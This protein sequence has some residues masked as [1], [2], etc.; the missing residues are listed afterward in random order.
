MK[1]LSIRRRVVSTASVRSAQNL[2]EAS[3]AISS[4]TG[5]AKASIASVD[6]PE[7][8]QQVGG[9]NFEV[10]EQQV[11][12]DGIERRTK[13]VQ[14]EV[15]NVQSSSNSQKVSL[16]EQTKLL[17][18]NNKCKSID[19]KIL[20][21][22]HQLD[23][24][25]QTKEES[26][27]AKSHD[28]IK[29]A[30]RIKEDKSKQS[31]LKANE[32]NITSEQQQQEQSA[33]INSSCKFVPTGNEEQQQQQATGV[34]KKGNSFLDALIEGRKSWF[35][36]RTIIVDIRNTKTNNNETNSQRRDKSDLIKNKVSCDEKCKIIK[37]FDRDE[38]QLDSLNQ[39]NST[40]NNYLNNEQFPN[41]SKSEKSNNPTKLASKS[42][43]QINTKT[44]S[45]NNNNKTNNNSGYI[46]NKLINNDSS[47]IGEQGSGKLIQVE[48][49][50]G[51]DKKVRK[52]NISSIKEQ[53]RQII[54]NTPDYKQLRQQQQD[55]ETTN[56]TKGK[57][58]EERQLK[59]QQQQVG[60]NK[61]TNNPGSTQ[62]PKGKTPPT[63]GGTPYKVSRLPYYSYHGRARNVDLITAADREDRLNR[64]R[65]SSN[66]KKQSISGGYIDASQSDSSNSFDSSSGGEPEKSSSSSQIN[67]G[68]SKSAAS[69]SAE[70]AANSG[71]KVVPTLSRTSGYRDSRQI[72]EESA[73]DDEYSKRS[74]ERQNINYSNESIE[75]TNL[76]STNKRRFF[77]NGFS[78]ISNLFPDQQM[79]NYHSSKAVADQQRERNRQLRFNSEERLASRTRQ[80]Q[81]WNSL[82]NLN[83][84]SRGKTSGSSRFAPSLLSRRNSITNYQHTNNSRYIRPNRS[85][86]SLDTSPYSNTSDNQ[87]QQQQQQQQR[88]TMRRQNSNSGN[89]SGAKQRGA[90][91]QGRSMSASSAY[92]SRHHR[93]PSASSLHY[94]SAGTSPY[95]PPPIDPDCP[96]HGYSPVNQVHSKSSQHLASANSDADLLYEPYNVG[97]YDRG[98]PAAAAVP[99]VAAGGSLYSPISPPLIDRSQTTGLVGAGGG[100]YPVQG[101]GGRLLAA[102]NG[103]PNA[104]YNNTSRFS[105]YHSPMNGLDNVR[106][107]LAPPNEQLRRILGYQPHARPI[108]LHPQWAY[109]RPFIHL[110][111]TRTPSP[112]SPGLEGDDDDLIGGIGS[113]GADI[114]PRFEQY[115]QL[116]DTQAIRAVDFHP[117]GEVYAVG[118]NSRALRICAYPADY[119]LRHFSHDHVT[120]APRILFKFLQV[121]RG[122][123]YCVSFNSTGQ[124]L[125]TGSNDQTV[126]IVKYN[127]ITHS[128]DGDEYRLT[129][130][131]GTVRDLCFIDDSP[132]NGHSSI[133]LSAGGG[134]NKIY[135]TDCDT[136]TPFQSMAGHTQMIMA[137][138][139]WGGSNF[140]S[141]S[142]DRTIRFWDLRTRSCTSIISA[143]TGIVS[144]GTATGGKWAGPGAPVCAVK[145]DPTGRLLASGHNDSTCMLYDIRGARIIQAFKLHDDEI[146]TV[147]FSPKSYYLLTGGYDGRIVLTDIQGDLTQPLPSVCVA[148]SDDKIVQSKWHPSDF[149]FVTTSADKTA[150]LWAMPTE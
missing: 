146:R 122:S 83:Q 1:A 129:M 25:N 135:V 140:V 119:E 67:T 12:G 70:S 87:L 5:L 92:A 147:S 78:N 33:T 45:A 144:G 58:A 44:L 127:S 84:P 21:C 96:V 66:T 52:E 101:K 85:M 8:Q 41:N 75:N 56:K 99:P 18:G 79:N 93:S 15:C 68:S 64:D 117:S 145:V 138:H 23:G 112:G 131:D 62:A 31:K 120:T 130:H 61:V 108:Y 143:P 60:F 149:T 73:N 19:D 36:E 77:K 123:I 88:S 3:G 57:K 91:Y 89:G 2:A 46:K 139:H 134:D 35:E 109:S 24:N 51:S 116:H 43:N 54:D 95:G 81:H 13:K 17:T 150:T 20:S 6:I 80:Q 42:S 128:P 82:S 94:G 69:S 114:R 50:R 102:S 107:T 74:L 40:R 48:E 118:S 53:Q 111:G 98:I 142:Y 47:N 126:H 104:Y 72:N 49:E 110:Q 63:F 10:I 59:Q 34:K 115:N 125:A 100:S 132:N 133:L 113:A 32:S 121:H 148:E 14:K 7:Q 141:A 30:A 65:S 29:L 76:K 106:S 71:G 28:P 137:L 124:L 105:M 86:N 26:L 16:E 90:S 55:T 4:V 27:P 97:Y 22:N 11:S 103:N 9:N 39:T 136:I 37:H 38:E